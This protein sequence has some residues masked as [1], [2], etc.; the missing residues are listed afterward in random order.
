MHTRTLWLSGPSQPPQRT[1]ALAYVITAEKTTVCRRSSML[2]GAAH[3]MESCCIRDAPTLGSRIIR[4]SRTLGRTWT[5]PSIWT[6]ALSR[7]PA[8]GASN[9]QTLRPPDVARALDIQ[10][11]RRD[12]SRQ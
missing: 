8:P 1:A 5:S 12:E 3:Q 2:V 11:A 4:L 9:D 10:T 6:G 7:R